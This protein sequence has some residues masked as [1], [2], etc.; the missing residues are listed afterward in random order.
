VG[1]IALGF[2]SREIAEELVISERT[3]DTHADNI[4]AKLG[5]RSRAEVAAWGTEN[6]LRPSRI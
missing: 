6:G 1:L 3:L 5:L 4:R 2:T